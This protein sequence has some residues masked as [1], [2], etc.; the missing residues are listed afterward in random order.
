MKLEANFVCSRVSKLRLA[1][2]IRSAKP[3][4]PATKTFCQ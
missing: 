3:F 2:Q 1:G 4:H